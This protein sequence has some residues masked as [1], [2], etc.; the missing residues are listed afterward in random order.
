[1]PSRWLHRLLFLVTVAS[2]L[3]LALLVVLC[4][5]LDSG[6]QPPEGWGRLTAAFARDGAVRRTA[7]AAAVG[8]V[9]TAWVFFR[10]GA[11]SRLK[12]RKRPRLPPSGGSVGA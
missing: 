7:I 3:T 10:P 12:G 11:L 4:P 5:W 2:A 9:V 8:L 1:M 6:G